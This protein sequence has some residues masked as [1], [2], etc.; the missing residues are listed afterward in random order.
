M[1]DLPVHSYWHW[2]L[3]MK[4]DAVYTDNTKA[5]EPVSHLKLL[6]MTEAY[7][8]K[9]DLFEWISLLKDHTQ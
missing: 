4:V 3:N 2:T 6:P 5:F 9:L 1:R 8:F 7:G